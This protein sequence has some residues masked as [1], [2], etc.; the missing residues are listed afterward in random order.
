MVKEKILTTLAI[1]AFAISG[2]GAGIT[3]YQYYYHSGPNV[4]GLAISQNQGTTNLT[5]S[6]TVAINFTINNINFGTG[7]VL[8]GST[9]ATLVTGGANNTNGTWQ[10]VT[11][12]FVIANIGNIN[13]SLWLSTNK[14]AAEFIGG[15]NPAYQYNVTNNASSCPGAAIASRQF[16]K[17]YD[18]NNTN[19]TSPWFGD[20]IC[21]NMSYIQGNNNVT[22]DIKLIVPSDSFTGSLGDFMT[23]TAQ[24]AY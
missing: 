22:V 15:T 6:Q 1:I 7:Y 2:I 20:Y 8:P 13:V 21:R 11:Q 19:S 17:W 23:A 3:W 5:V 9:A 16:N 14:T 18:V 12:G 24:N 4:S 10:N